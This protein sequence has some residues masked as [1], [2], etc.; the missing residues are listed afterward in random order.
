M[1]IH[2]HPWND[3]RAPAGVFEQVERAALKA[4]PERRPE[5]V[6]WHRAK[7]HR[8]CHVVFRGA[9]YSA[10]WTPVG[11]QLWC[12][13]R[14]ARAWGTLACSSDER[15]APRYGYPY[16]AVISFDTELPRSTPCPAPR[17]PPEPSQLGDCKRR[18][19]TCHATVYQSA[20][21]VIC[22]ARSRRS[23]LLFP[24]PMREEDDSQA[25]TA[26]HILLARR[27]RL[28]VESARGARF[29]E[30]QARLLAAEKSCNLPTP[31]S[32]SP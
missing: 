32:T 3:G 21:E 24:I 29:E 15:R 25:R 30:E 16:R 8:D 28:L 7:L 14:G 26:L 22:P 19:E 10:P 4:L 1:R 13:G 31:R 18:V 23:S 2:G 27:D 20:S 6:L 11:K 9:M 5:L 12:T 17:P